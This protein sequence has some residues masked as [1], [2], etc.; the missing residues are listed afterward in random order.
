[1][2]ALCESDCEGR[3]VL[4]LSGLDVQIR[5]QGLAFR[6]AKEETPSVWLDNEKEGYVLSVNYHCGN[7]FQQK[8]DTEESS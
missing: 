8:S 7:S 6:S 1:V 5:R 2:N 4:F 3:H